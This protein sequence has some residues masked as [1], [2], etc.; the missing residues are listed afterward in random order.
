[1]I[2]LWVFIGFMIGGAVGVSIMSMLFAAS[3]ADDVEG[4]YDDEGD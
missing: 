3:N 2:A 4:D 1:M